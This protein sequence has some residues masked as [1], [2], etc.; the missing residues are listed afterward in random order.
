MRVFVGFIST[1]VFGFSALGVTFTVEGECRGKIGGALSWEG[2]LGA[3]FAHRLG[4]TEIS[5][6]LDEGAL[7]G[8][9]WTDRGRIGIFRYE[10]AVAVSPE[11]LKLSSLGISFPWSGAEVRW[12][13][14]LEGKGFGWG[15]EIRGGFGVVEGIKARWNLRPFS[16]RVEEET[17]GPGFSYGEVRFAMGG[18]CGE[19]VRGHLSMTKEGLDE[20]SLHFSLPLWDT[21]RVGFSL[22]LKMGT[23][24]KRVEARPQLA[25]E[26][27]T[28]A[29]AFVRFLWEE[30][31]ITGLELYGLGLHCRFENWRF[32]VLAETGDVDLVRGGDLSI[33]LYL[34]APRGNWAAQGE[35]VLGEAGELFALEEVRVGF[36]WNHNWG[37][38]Q[39]SLS[40]PAEDSPK[41]KLQTRLSWEIP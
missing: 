32:R 24:R 11:G 3:G 35:A 34:E 8:L 23:E 33:A 40:F 17:F 21:P 26:F 6:L 1:F 28:C 30:G 16:D 18:C 29:E 4:E 12:V 38:L 39:L 9:R 20:L 36:L 7:E 22:R 19:S 2:K 5:F 15:L 13:G 25:L 41:A 31:T 27:P 14:V 37:K 10:G